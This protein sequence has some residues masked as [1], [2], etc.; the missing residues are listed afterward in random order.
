MTLKLYLGI[1][2]KAQSLKSLRINKTLKPLFLCITVSSGLKSLRINKTLKLSE[3][4]SQWIYGL[5]SLRINKTL[6][7]Q[8]PDTSAALV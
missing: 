7:P 8:A 2:G 4:I 6:K 1:P 3:L 5:K